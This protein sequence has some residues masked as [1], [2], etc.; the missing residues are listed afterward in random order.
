MEDIRRHPWHPFRN[1]GRVL[2]GTSACLIV[3]SIMIVSPILWWEAQSRPG[4]TN[5]QNVTLTNK[6]RT[7]LAATTTHTQHHRTRRSVEFTTKLQLNFTEGL[8]SS[9]TIDLCDIIACT[10]DQK[11][12]T[13]D[14]IYI[15]ET[16]M[17]TRYAF[18]QHQFCDSWS[19]VITNT[20]NDWGYT[21]PLTNPSSRSR[22]NRL[23]VIKQLDTHQ[24][25]GGSCN[26]LVITLKDPQISDTSMY[27]LA[28]DM[29]GKDKMGHFYINV[30]R[31]GTPTVKTPT[32]SHVTQLTGLTQD[33]VLAMETGFGD[34]NVWVA[35][36]RYTAMQKKR[37][38]CVICSSGC[39]TTY[40]APALM[41]PQCPQFQF[42]LFVGTSYEQICVPQV[43]N[44]KKHLSTSS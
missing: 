42:S 41:Y 40:T 25:S 4:L 38:N 14:I 21:P 1:T 10:E 15:C 24:C 28:V 18:T 29:T 3:V 12:G 5:G 32:D 17:D 34:T 37:S 27:V 43:Q 13:T 35:W 44:L 33:Q 6:T 11:Q 39:T 9:V 8:T 20:G 7:G 16:Y 2:R 30:Q 23:T 22:K 36:M 19:Y 26:P 31:N